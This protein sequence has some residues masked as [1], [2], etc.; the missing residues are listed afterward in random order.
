MTERT[1]SIEGCGRKH[2]ARGWCYRHYSRWWST[3]SVGPVGTLVAKREPTCTVNGC[4]RPHAARGYCR[5][6][7]WRWQKHQSADL[8]GD[9]FGQWF[10]SHVAKNVVEECWDWTGPQDELGYG[11]FR[12]RR[13]SLWAHRVSYELTTGSIPSGLVIDHLCR[14]PSCVNP[15]HLEAV[16]QRV[17]VLRGTAPTAVNA[18]KTHCKRG[19]EFTAANTYIIPS[20]GSRVCRTCRRDYGR[21]WD[22]RRRAAART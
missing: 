22:K 13:R 3:G 20:T 9:D 17:N 18:A 7:Y 2:F 8:P 12:H 11:R 14:R 19:H 6:H 15:A 5:K 4:D 16:E 21:E 1:C 10:W